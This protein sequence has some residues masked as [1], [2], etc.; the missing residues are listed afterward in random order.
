MIQLPKHVHSTITLLGSER[1]AQSIRNFGSTPDNGIP[2][3]L[4]G[5]NTLQVPVTFTYADD[6]DPGPYPIPPNV[7]IEG[8]STAAPDLISGYMIL[9]DRCAM[10]ALRSRRSQSSTGWKLDQ[11]QVQESRWICGMI[12][13]GLN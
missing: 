12:L 10:P 2:I 3:T 1:A 5:P 9:V 8:G 13:C 4:I 7:R 11:P 6:S